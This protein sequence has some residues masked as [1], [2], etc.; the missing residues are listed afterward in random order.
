[1][2]FGF[3]LQVSWLKPR[4][5]HPSTLSGNFAQ[6]QLLKWSENQ[7]AAIHWSSFKLPCSCHHQKALVVSGWDVNV[8]QQNVNF[9]H[10]E[11]GRGCI[12]SWTTLGCCAFEKFSGGYLS[13]FFL[14]HMRPF[15]RLG[16]LVKLL[17]AESHRSYWNKIYRCQGGVWDF[18]CFYTSTSLKQPCRTGLL[19]HSEHEYTSERRTGREENKLVAAKVHRWTLGLLPA[20]EMLLELNSW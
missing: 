11:G 8:L 4:I 20:L 18:G 1:M 7:A 2:V 6:G 9:W 15:Y 17:V 19:C 13:S 3:K 12:A 10:A 16:V 14:P 5:Q